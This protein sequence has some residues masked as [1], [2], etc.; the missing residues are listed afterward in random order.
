[1]KSDEEAFAAAAGFVMFLAPDRGV[2]ELDLDLTVFALD[3][4]EGSF[5]LIQQCSIDCFIP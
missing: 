1:M 3:I 2:L 5:D 4:L